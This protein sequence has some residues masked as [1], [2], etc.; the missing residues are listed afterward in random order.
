LGTRKQGREWIGQQRE[1][2]LKSKLKTVLPAVEALPIAGQLR[3]SIG[4][5]LSKNA[6]R[7]YYLAY[8]QRG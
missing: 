5:Y 3:D 1:G 2:L 4:Q 7:M 6:Y 8:R